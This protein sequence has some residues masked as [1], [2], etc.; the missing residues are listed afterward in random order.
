MNSQPSINK[1]TQIKNP[2]QILQ[3][4]QTGNQRFMANS[5]LNRD[6]HSG[7]D[8]TKNGQQPIA[9]VLSCMDSRV[10]AE[11]VF[12]QGIGDIFNIRIAGNVITPE[13]LGSLEYAVA[14]TGTPVILILGHTGCG[15]IGGACDQVSLGNLTGLLEKIQPAILAEKTEQHNRSS[16]NPDFVRKVTLLH[17]ENVLK[18]MLEQ[19]EV[20]Q[21]A[22]TENRLLVTT[23][24]Y[25]VSSGEV[26]FL[27]GKMDLEV[28]NDCPKI[29]NSPVI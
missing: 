5:R 7:I 8:A 25:D 28:N 20:I 27:A 21:V 19:S 18:E 14:V 12:D 23:A 17:L 29:K 4:L 9:A 22:V 11:L 6:H 2:G 3:I 13:V 26:T 15:A 1:T 24:I 10:A 16:Q